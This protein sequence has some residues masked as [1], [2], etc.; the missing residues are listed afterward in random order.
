[1]IM[2]KRICRYSSQIGK[3]KKSTWLKRRL[4]AFMLS[5]SLVAGGV[6]SPTLFTGGRN[7]VE[8]VV[9]VEAATVDVWDGSVATGYNGGSGTSED[10]YTI[11]TGAQL[12]YLSEQVKDSNPYR[13]VYFKLINDIDLNNIN[14]T[15]IGGANANSTVDNAFR[16]YFDGSGF[17]I[18]GLYQDS[19]KYSYGLFGW[20]SGANDNSWAVV[21][22]LTVEGAINATA[23]E[24]D[25]GGIVGICIDAQIIN[26]INKVN[27]QVQGKFSDGDVAVGGIVGEYFSMS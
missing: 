22:N 5:I 13:G 20:V 14:W 3:S 6:Y 2:K 1:M 18:R 9:E 7:G 19:G 23:Y 17:T 8:E 11:S 26:C 21:K 12:A 25:I 27:I 16:G 24:G 15:S 10:P 4:T